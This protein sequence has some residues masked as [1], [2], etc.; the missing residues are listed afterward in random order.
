MDERLL[1]GG[2]VEVEKKINVHLSVTREESKKIQEAAEKAGLTKAKYV[3]S[4]ALEEDIYEAPT[5]ELMSAFFLVRDLEKGILASG[6]ESLIE[7]IGKVRAALLK[8]YY[9]SI[10]ESNDNEIEEMGL[11]YK[12]LN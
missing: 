12:Y 10:G 1:N 9:M 2:V 8:A 7:K 5:K 11:N 6:N 4:K 3:R